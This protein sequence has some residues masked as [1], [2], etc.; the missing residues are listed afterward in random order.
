VTSS[1]IGNFAQAIIRVIRRD[2]DTIA[3][4]VV[5]LGNHVPEINPDAGLPQEQVLSSIQR[6]GEIFAS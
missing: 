5:L 6:L 1:M 4:D 3:E 2:I